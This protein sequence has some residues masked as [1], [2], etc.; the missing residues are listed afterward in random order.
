MIAK[1]IE[2]EEIPVAHISA[3]SMVSTQV[4]ASRTVLG[5]KIPHPCGDPT[6]PPEADHALRRE[7]IKCAL[8]ALQADISES[9]NF[10]P[11]VVSKL[12]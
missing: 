7:I 5:T 10:V 9:T 6:L 3:M 2:R 1:E 11:D 4:G 12:D 8:G